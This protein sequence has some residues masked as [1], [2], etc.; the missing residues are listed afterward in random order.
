MTT[1]YLVR[2]GIADSYSPTGQ[3]SGRHLTPEGERRIE[4]IG[5]ALHNRS[6]LPDM[7]IASPY[8]RAQQTAAI[9]AAKVEYSHA[10]E[11]DQRLIPVATPR[12][13]HT[14]L[15]EWKDKDSLM[16]V[17]HEPW[18]SSAVT[19]LIATGIL[20]IA[21]EPGSVCCVNIE[22]LH[23]PGGSLRWFLTSELV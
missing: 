19:L 3:D 21:Y 1:L 16:L 13:V 6:I 20:A 11:S 15:Q 17:G 14:F 5:T 18:M 2:H 4:R 7:I 8:T 22:R 10:I 12:T 9:L 23:P